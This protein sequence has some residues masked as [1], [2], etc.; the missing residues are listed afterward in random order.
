RVIESAL[1]IIAVAICQLPGR[2]TIIRAKYSTVLRFDDCPNSFGVRGRHGDTHFP[3]SARRHSRIAAEIGPVF[4]A[5]CRLPKFGAWSAAT[6]R[7]WRSEC[8]PCC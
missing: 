2:A 8:L 1:T 7:P 3:E 4:S 5:V 6:Q